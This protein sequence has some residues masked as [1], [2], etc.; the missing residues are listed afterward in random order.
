MLTIALLA[1]IAYA[2]SYLSPETDKFLYGLSGL[3]FIVAGAS[4]FIYDEYSGIPIGETVSYSYTQVDNQTVVSE[5]T[6]RTDYLDSTYYPE[7][8]A[9]IFLLTGLILWTFLGLEESYG[10]KK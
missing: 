3:L 6:T 4:G 1:A 9:V 2:M 8:L 5:E 7:S 10:T